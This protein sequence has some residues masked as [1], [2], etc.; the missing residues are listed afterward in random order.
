MSDT[1]IAASPALPGW[2][3]AAD[4]AA[5]VTLAVGVFVLLFG[6][7]VLHFG[8]V[9]LRVHGAERVLFIALALIAIRHTAHPAPPLHRRL[10]QGLRAGGEG[11]AVSIARGS[12]AV[13]VAVLVVGY[14]AVVPIGIA[15]GVGGFGVSP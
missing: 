14:F 13:R 11:S 7:F 6:G 4:A 1:D 10:I 15:R 12:V 5:V 2:V 3:R 8:P 9:L